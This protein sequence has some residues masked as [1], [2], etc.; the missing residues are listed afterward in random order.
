MSTK[1]IA[2]Q[3]EHLRK[4]RFR[5]S[6]LVWLAGNTFYGRRE[7]FESAFLECPPASLLLPRVASFFSG[8]ELFA[9]GDGR[10]YS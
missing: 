9:F 4:L 2:E 1:E 5:K 3:L 10:A 8:T 6:E 7:I